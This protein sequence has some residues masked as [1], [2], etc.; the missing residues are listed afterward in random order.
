MITER[1]WHG[2]EVEAGVG[3]DA[4]GPVASARQMTGGAMGQPPGTWGTCG[5]P[6][7]TPRSDKGC[8]GASHEF[9]D[10]LAGMPCTCGAMRFEQGVGGVIRMV[11]VPSDLDGLREAIKEVHAL[12][13]DQGEVMKVPMSW[14][15]DESWEMPV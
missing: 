8:R 2:L 3:Y 15:W 1:E 6:T 4:L 11:G 14:K 13:R 12:T 9:L 7:P 5:G 10:V